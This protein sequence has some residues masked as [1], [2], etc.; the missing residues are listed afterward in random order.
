M[1]WPLH[2]VAVHMLRKQDSLAWLELPYTSHLEDRNGEPLVEVDQTVFLGV[3][4]EAALLHVDTVAGWAVYT[5]QG[6]AGWLLLWWW[7]L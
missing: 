3:D 4:V 1:S 6:A 2:L 7:W 5:Q